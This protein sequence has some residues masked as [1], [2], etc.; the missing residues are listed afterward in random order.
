LKNILNKN[1]TYANDLRVGKIGDARALVVECY[2]HV[3]HP[4]LKNV[5]A[6]VVTLSFM[7]DVLRKHVTL[8]IATLVNADDII[9]KSAYH[10]P[11]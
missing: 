5:N 7:K 6:D 10:A 4:V 3:V 8:T 11:I 9:I 2:A 1:T